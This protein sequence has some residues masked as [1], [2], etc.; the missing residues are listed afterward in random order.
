[1]SSR[2]HVDYPDEPVHWFAGYRQR[3]RAVLGDCPH[4][5]C[6]HKETTVIGWGPDTLHYELVICVSDGCAGNCRGW[7]AAPSGYRE[8]EAVQW[9]QLTAAV[10]A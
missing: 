9:K 7:C 8:L 10:T 2:V 5:D 4:R 3:N 1:M 6:G